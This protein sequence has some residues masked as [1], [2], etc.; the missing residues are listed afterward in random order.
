VEKPLFT[1]RKGPGLAWV[2]LVAFIVAAGGF[3]S[4]FVMNRGQ[5]GGVKIY[6]MITE[7]AGSIVFKEKTHLNILVL[8]LDESRDERGIIH[9]KGSRTD[10]IFMLGLDKGARRLGML[11]IPRD[12]WVH[13]I[14]EHPDNR[15]NAAY[16]DAFWD[17]YEK[18]GHNYPSSKAA[19]IS[20]VRRTVDDFLGVRADYFV[21]IKI[22][23]AAQLIDAIGGLMLDVEKDMDYD[24]NWGNLHI[25]LK[26]GRQRLNGK[27][28]VGYARFRHD[29]EG[30]WGRI[31][32]QQQLIQ[33]LV[34]ELKKP[35]HIM[36]IDKIARVIKDNIETDLDLNRIIDIAR[37]YKEFDRSH[38]IKGVIMGE[39]EMIEKN[40]VI[41]PDEK[42]KKRYVDR[43]LRNPSLIRNDELFVRVLNG[44]GVAGLGAK[45]AEKLKSRG[46]N[47]VEVG[48]VEDA[49]KDKTGANPGV[50]PSPASTAK[51]LE[52]T[53]IVDH[54]L[55]E[56]GAVRIRD[57]LGVPAAAI[58]H[59]KSKNT[60]PT[61]DY[62][63]KLGKDLTETVGSGP[64]KTG[65]EGP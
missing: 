4:Y 60:D 52:K 35:A 63:I 27:D 58:V 50:S 41:R 36:Q 29:E 8:G 15:I 5:I 17:E 38:V 1:R 11:S 6:S 45:T 54:F 51:P 18:S 53:V 46:Y 10:T 40:M 28:A 9:H 19:G 12:T 37:V 13:S 21:L 30:D 39:D 26:K 3:L 34:D 14:D 2:L 59:E 49:D 16:G 31:R 55:S 22:E 7:P 47:V 20:R 61:L 42:I 57:S 33:A 48:N 64:E 24:D 32:R 23:A 56:A 65:E 25:H 44:C 43:I 62:T